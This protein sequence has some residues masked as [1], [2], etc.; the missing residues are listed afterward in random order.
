[1]CSSDLTFEPHRL[2]EFTGKVRRGKEWDAFKAAQGDDAVIVNAKE[3]AH[4]Q[5]IATA[6]TLDPRASAIIFRPDALL[7]QPIAWARDGRACSSRPDV[8]VPG[9]LVADLKTCRSAQPARFVRESTWA[10]YHVQLRFYDFADAADTGRTPWDPST[11]KGDR[12]D[13]YSIAVESKRPHVV[14]VF[15]LDDTAIVDADRRISLW[16]SRLMAC[17]AE[18]AWHGYS[19][20]VE[21]F[22]CDDPENFLIAPAIDAENEN[23]SDEDEDWSAA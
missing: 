12:I 17:E 3:L 2:V 23:A 22:T 15:A 18:N 5:R 16:W 9:V 10:G 11:R 8:R 14:T 13:L 20:C 6:L 4:A 21:P 19:Q 1:M 7:E